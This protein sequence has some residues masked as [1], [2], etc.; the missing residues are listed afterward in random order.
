MVCENEREVIRLVKRILTNQME[1]VIDRKY[2]DR[3]YYLLKERTTDSIVRIQTDNRLLSSVFW[4]SYHPMG[5]D[6]P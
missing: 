6:A 3:A 1:Y 4:N 2:P 5:G